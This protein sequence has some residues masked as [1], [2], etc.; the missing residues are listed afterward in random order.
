LKVSGPDLAVTEGIAFWIGT[1]ENVF[2][3]GPKLPAK[4]RVIMW[5]VLLCPLLY[6]LLLPP[7]FHAGMFAVLHWYPRLRIT[8]PGR[9]AV[10]N[11][12]GACG[13]PYWM[14]AENSPLPLEMAFFEYDAWWRYKVRD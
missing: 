13:K 3:M 8:Y 10:I 11:V 12:L 7:L 1:G 14:L 5:A 9:P 4:Y 6:V 2:S